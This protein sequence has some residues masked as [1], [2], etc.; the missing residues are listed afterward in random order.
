[1]VFEGREM[2]CMLGNN[3]LSFGADCLYFGKSCDL[4]TWHQ[5]IEQKGLCRPKSKGA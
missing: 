4:M 2:V 5:V 1:M 3:L